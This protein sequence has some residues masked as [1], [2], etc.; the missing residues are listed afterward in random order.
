MEAHV[1]GRTL[2]G[3]SPEVDPRLA[4]ALHGHEV[5]AQPAPLGGVGL[6]A[7][8]GGSKDAG[9][10]QHGLLGRPL[11]RQGRDGV[12]RDVTDRRRPLRGLGRLV[13][14]LAQDVL[15]PFVKTVGAVLDEEVIVGVLGEPHVGD[16]LGQRRV[17]ARARSY[18]LVAHGARGAVVVRV[19]DHE[20]DAH[21]LHPV[22]PDE[23]LLAAV[24]VGGAVGVHRPE[25]DLLG[26]LEGVLQQLGLL[27][28]AQAP[29]VA[30]GVGRA[31]VPPLPAVRVVEAHA[32]AQDVEEAAQGPELVVE[33]APVVMGR[34]HGGDG[35]R[36]V[37]LPDAGDLAGN[38]VQRLI[39]GDALVLVL[40]PQFRMPVPVGIEVLAL[41]GVVD[42]VVVDALP[43]RHFPALQRGLA[44][45]GVL[46][47]PRVDGPRR[48]VGLVEDDRAHPGD[49][50]VLDVHP[51]RPADRALY[52]NLFR[53]LSPPHHQV[54]CREQLLAMFAFSGARLALPLAPVG[55]R[56]NVV[57]PVR[58]RQTG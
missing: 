4:E 21:F 12:S 9:H 11:A 47:A 24:H 31:P 34:G 58:V 5:D 49:D 18:P 50:A 32:V 54:T 6:T 26:V 57:R 55:A 40:A 39:P 42:P 28:V 20:L 2:A 45:R 56:G 15:L 10:G 3:A 7:G 37:R 48:G 38:E 30:P 19:D 1:E 25:D 22:T 35:R 43:L 51:H 27:A 46:L 36:A 29:P 41:E 17:G 53:H 23:V 33:E 13:L 52:K 44:R 16:G 8:A 14:A